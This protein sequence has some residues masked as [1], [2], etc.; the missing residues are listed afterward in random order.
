MTDFTIPPDNTA[1]LVLNSGDI[2]R[3]EDHGR[4]HDITVNDGASEA[5]V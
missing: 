3:V 4:S 2:L 1:P 5:V